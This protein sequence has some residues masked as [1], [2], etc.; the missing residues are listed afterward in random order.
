[1]PAH[2]PR[3]LQLN[4]EFLIDFFQVSLIQP[5]TLLPIFQHQVSLPFWLFIPRLFVPPAVY[6][7]GKP[8]VHL[9][10]CIFYLCKN[11]TNPLLRLY[12]SS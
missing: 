7:S 10:R 9:I 11:H 2:I 1:M 5:T 3:Q 6:P 4:F 12:S 8:V